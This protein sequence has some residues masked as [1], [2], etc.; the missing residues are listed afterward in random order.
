MT[1]AAE[2]AREQLVTAVNKI[3]LPIVADKFK[4]ARLSDFQMRTVA[5]VCS[6]LD[7]HRGVFATGPRGRGK[8]HL[9]AAVVREY[10]LRRGEVCLADCWRTR[11]INGW[12]GMP[13]T[14]DE[15]DRYIAVSLSAAG[16]A[17]RGVVFGDA[18]EIMDDIRAVFDGDGR[19]KQDVVDGYARAE[20]LVVDD[21]GMDK[22]S[23][24]VRE[25]FDSIVNRRW[26]DGL[27]SVFTSNLDFGELDDHYKDRG[28]MTS[29]ITGMCDVIELVGDDRRA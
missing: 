11:D 21:I 23:E 9:A 20:L 5:S 24:F 13:I 26:A 2:Q 14:D 17:L 22:N 8:T 12:Q 7:A 4:S 19:R 29:R 3:T 25:T 16:Q 1:A 6:A 10:M 27:L 18:V 28:R 15:V